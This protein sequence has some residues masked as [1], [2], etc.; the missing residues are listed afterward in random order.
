METQQDSSARCFALVLV[1]TPEG[2]MLPVDSE[3][4]ISLFNS[5]ISTEIFAQDGGNYTEKFTNEFK[6]LIWDLQLVN[7]EYPSS[8]EPTVDTADGGRPNMRDTEN[9][10]VMKMVKSWPE[11]SNEFVLV[12][13]DQLGSDSRLCLTTIE[14]LSYRSKEILEAREAFFAPTPITAIATRETVKMTEPANNAP[15]TAKTARIEAPNALLES[16]KDLVVIIPTFNGQRMTGSA[17]RRGC[18]T[19]FHERLCIPQLSKYAETDA[20]RLAK[21]IPSFDEIEEIGTFIVTNGERSL[22]VHAFVAKITS[23]AQAQVN[24]NLRPI[25][26]HELV[27]ESERYDLFSLDLY[28]RT[29]EAK[30]EQKAS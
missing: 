1:C 27:T 17:S 15:V 7:V 23:I 13:Y 24:T 25:A 18:W 9:L 6:R 14:A 29:A 10:F 21:K 16:G 30:L 3:N 2:L 26:Q 22:T 11:D 5:R 19:A 8:F 12:P 20:L 28:A 4:V